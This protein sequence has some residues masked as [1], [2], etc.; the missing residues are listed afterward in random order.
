MPEL[1]EVET[2]M[3]GLAKAIAGRQLLDVEV[4]SKRLRLPVPPA[5]ARLR[6]LRIGKLSRRAK[7]ILIPLAGGQSII[8]HLGMTGRVLIYDKAAR[9]AYVRQKHDHFRLNFADG[10]FVVYNDARRFGLVDLCPSDAIDAHPFFAHLGPEP[11]DPA[12]DARSLA[13]ALANRRTAV[14]VALMDQR[15]VVGVGNIYAAE[16]LHRAKIDPRRPSGSMTAAE[17][18]ALVRDIRAVL[19]QSIDAGGSSL[20]DYVQ[21]DGE[22]GYYQDQWRVYGRDGEKC[23]RRGCP[24]HIA[25]IVQGGRSTFFC[26]DCQA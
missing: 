22:L 18:R 2:V 26:P 3:R 1:P 16:A 25:R 14:K 15:L 19:Q 8:L 9:A 12:F 21:T 23:L 20:R 5:L 24:G 17:T 10:S 11:F 7:Y 4:Y 6:N 13:A